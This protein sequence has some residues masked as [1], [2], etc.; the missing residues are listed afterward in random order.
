MREKISLFIS[1][2]ITDF[3]RKRFRI[4]D[5]PKIRIIYG[6]LIAVQ[7]LFEELTVL[8]KQL[9]VGVHLAFFP[10]VTDH[11]PVQPGLVFPA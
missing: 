1:N 11:I 2:I 4:Y 8:E 10:Q 3:S 6:I 5:L 9:A 7:A